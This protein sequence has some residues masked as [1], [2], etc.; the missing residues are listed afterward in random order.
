M[1]KLR[2]SD[3]YSAAYSR[4]NYDHAPYLARAAK[5][6]AAIKGKPSLLAGTGAIHKRLSGLSFGTGST[7][8]GNV[9]QLALKCLNIT[10]YMVLVDGKATFC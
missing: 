8:T 9:A 3:S 5:P 7:G 6:S 2:R 1:P 4:R 10:I